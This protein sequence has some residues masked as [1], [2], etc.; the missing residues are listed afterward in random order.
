MAFTSSGRGTAVSCVCALT[1]LFAGCE[2][3]TDSG[4]NP[5]APSALASLLVGT[6]GSGS[7]GPAEVGSCTGF[8]W[9]VS[10]QN[11]TTYSGNFSAT[12]S[13]VPLEGTLTGVL[14]GDKLNITGSGNAMPSA[15]TT[16]PFTL[17]GTAYVVGDRLQLDYTANSCLGPLS[18]TE[19]LGQL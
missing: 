17:N 4:L 1:I 10:Q 6:W 2:I 18:G 19:I 16:C 7:N 13:G 15:S 3:T 8:E 9:S 12:C 14:V 11:A 5:T